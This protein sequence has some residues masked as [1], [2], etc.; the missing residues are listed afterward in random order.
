MAFSGSLIKSSGKCSKLCVNVTVSH[1]LL[2]QLIYIRH[3]F[4]D[5]LLHDTDNA[6]DFVGFEISFF[7]PPLQNTVPP[8][9]EQDKLCRLCF[10]SFPFSSSF[11]LHFA[12][13]VLIWFVGF[14]LLVGFGCVFFLFLPPS[15]LQTLSAQT[16][17]N[18]LMLFQSVVLK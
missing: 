15:L 5:V 8:S 14:L 13:G 12:W 10:L 4:F 18:Y 2:K 1:K 6:L 16:V 7:F 3:H 11:L 17:F 9:A